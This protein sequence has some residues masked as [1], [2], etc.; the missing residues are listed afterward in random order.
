VRKQ[1]GLKAARHGG[2]RFGMQHGGGH[3]YHAGMA[4]V[5]QKLSEA[6]A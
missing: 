6:S 4:L 1:C 5:M 3:L 2:E